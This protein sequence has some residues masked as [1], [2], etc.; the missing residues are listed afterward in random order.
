M[1]CNGDEGWGRIQVQVILINGIG[2]GKYFELI[3]E[4]RN[5]ALKGVTGITEYY[6]LG[7]LK[8]S[9]MYYVFVS[10]I[11]FNYSSITT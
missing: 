5:G 10:E 2:F 1:V 4:M 8:T 9:N 6:E 3:S 11:D 7:N